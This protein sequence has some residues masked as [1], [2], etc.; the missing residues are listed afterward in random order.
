M[1]ITAGKHRKRRI[2]SPDGKD[3]R[4]TSSMVR[5]AIFNVLMHGE[6]A[7]GD[8]TLLPEQT[9]ADICCGCGTLGLE[10]LSRGAGHVVFV[11]QNRTSLDLTKSN[12]AHLGEEENASFIKADATML[13]IARE[14]VSVVFLDPPYH[15]DFPNRMLKSLVKSEWLK[16]NA[17][18]V[19]EQSLNDEVPEHPALT[20]IKQKTYGK[21]QLAFYR[22]AI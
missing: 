3:I 13:P 21:T 9:V 11:D 2:E 6:P 7:E 10:A 5:E 8:D 22:Y 12:V 16:P 15:K 17:M 18:V 20:L 19:V 14:R 4:P 1:H